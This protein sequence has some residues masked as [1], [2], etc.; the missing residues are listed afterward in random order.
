MGRMRYLRAVLVTVECLDERIFRPVH[1]RVTATCRVAISRKILLPPLHIGAMLLPRCTSISSLSTSSSSDAARQRLPDLLGHRTHPAAVRRC[2]CWR[3]ASPRSRR[4][5]PSLCTARPCPGAGLGAEQPGHPERLS[6]GAE[7]RG[8]A[9]RAAV[10]PLAGPAGRHGADLGR[11]GYSGQ[12]L[13]WTYVSAFPIALVSGMT[14]WEL[15]RCQAEIAVAAAHRGGRDQ[16]ARAALPGS[17]LRPALVGGRHGAAAQM[18]A[19]N[20][21]MY[22]ACCIPSC[23]P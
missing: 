20:I 15:L 1:I 14:A 5:A 21:T 10:P 17:Q 6:A 2:G 3:P 23:C 19:S 4:V 13:V 9:Q 8:R 16:P 18:L 11:R 12:N 22:E 7:R